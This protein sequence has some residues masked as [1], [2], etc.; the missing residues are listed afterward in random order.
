[1]IMRAAVLTS[2]SLRHLFF[3]QTMADA[4]DVVLALHQPKVNYY[5]QVKQESLAIRGH[6]ARIA[7]AE[8][9]EFSGRLR[10]SA[11]Q[12]LN[13]VADI[14]ADAVVSEVRS[15]GV[16]VILLFGTAILS[17]AW[18]QAFPGRIINL[19][20]G[21]SPFYRGAATLFWPIANEELE[22][23]GATI[24]L[25]IDRV[26]AGGILRR[27][28]AEPRIGDSYYSLTTRL[29]RRSIEI[30]PQTVRDYLS[31]A[32]QPAPQETGNARAY[33]MRDF[34]EDALAR[35]LAYIGSGLTLEQIMTAER[36]KKCVC[37]L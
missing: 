37:S 29:I 19:H 5:E 9:E 20:L 32:I 18:L 27:I 15:A 12:G 28:K 26:D 13:T 2:T 21:L 7:Q 4:F 8:D 16:D 36:S 6:F 31:G 1:L 14:N 25:A 35:A 23:L 33:R 11:E 17:Q 34:D 3:L 30:M 22:C 24:H 10:S